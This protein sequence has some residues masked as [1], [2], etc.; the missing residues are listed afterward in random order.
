MKKIILVLMFAI[1]AA[2]SADANR[3][4]PGFV[5]ISFQTF[6]DELSP[7]GDWIYTSEY[8]YVWQPYFDRPE[9]FRPYSSNGDWVYTEYGWTWVSDYRWGW[10]PFHYGRWYF[11]DYFGWLWIPGNEW[12][13]AWVTWGSYNNYWGWAPL[14][15]NVYVNIDFKWMAPDFW[16]TFIP[17]RHFYSHGWHNYIYGRPIQV[18]HITNITNIYI[19]NNNQRNSW[20]NGPR[21]NDVERY[22]RRRV[23]RM[24]VVDS[25]R[26]D[27]LRAANGRVSI[28]RPQVEE[29]RNSYRPTQS[30]NFENARPANRITKQNPRSNDPGLNR[31]R[32]SRNDRSNDRQ[33][34]PGRQTTE[35]R[36]QPSRDNPSNDRNIEKKNEDRSKGNR[37]NEANPG[38]D[39]RKDKESKPG[40]RRKDEMTNDR[41]RESQIAEVNPVRYSERSEKTGQNTGYA[42]RSRES[43]SA[44]SMGSSSQSG[45]SGRNGVSANDS[46]SRKS[47][48]QG[49]SAD[50]NAQKNR[51]R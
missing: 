22:G 24:E 21:V 30:R 50:R 40:N 15:P 13:P 36:T 48:D 5:T 33:V 32:D 18:N 42:S 2:Y 31:T 8:G 10:A 4:R 45:T 25:E 43:G 29:S 17:C 11:D 37:G 46:P 27:N 14:G 38:N 20:F 23:Q 35:P 12:A 39:S 26:A 28:Y 44:K 47:G 16:W 6:Y 49:K 34:T 41:Q 1:V 9:D 3:Y 51:R 7:Y 19:N